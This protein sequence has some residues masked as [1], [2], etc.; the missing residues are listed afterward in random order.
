[1]GVPTLPVPVLALALALTLA[2]CGGVPKGP[3]LPDGPP[4][5]PASSD[6][7]AR[8]VS[9]SR[10]ADTALR[11]GD[12]ETAVGLFQEATLTDSG[13]LPAALGL[14]E[15]LLV[16][17]RDLEATRAFERAMQI[18]PKSPDARYGYAR[19][20]IGINRPEVAAEQLRA[21]VAASPTNVAAINAL[22]VAQDLLGDHAA[23]EAT[24]RQ[25]LAVMPGAESV[26]NNLALSLALQ[27]RFGEALDLLR[28]VAEGPNATRRSRQNLALVYGLKGDMAAA[29]RISRIDL[30]GEELANN[31]AYFA[32]LRGMAAP[33]LRALA[34]AP[35]DDPLLAEPRLTRKSKSVR[36]AVPAIA[37]QA[38]PPAVQPAAPASEPGAPTPLVP[39]LGAAAHTESAAGDWFVDL[40]TLAPAAAAES[41][42]RLR[43]EHRAEL[44]GT[45]LL[46]GAGA[47]PEP[48][49]VGPLASEESAV[50]LCGR[51]AAATATCHPTKL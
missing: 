45:E 1:M 41:W 29:E 36:R 21:I 17:G 37:D 30:G 40:G 19:A 15:A 49:L 22:G 12:S 10:I 6:A 42:R 5:A 48:M 2:G 26:R 47:A 39:I 14:G 3:V 33:N 51:L 34:L 32:A 24:Y 44:G 20:M 18:E 28:P 35:E 13:S 50:A 8:A 27:D 16:V 11:S 7:R 4:E 23:A 31:L 38:A 9:L 25:A 43:A 46:A